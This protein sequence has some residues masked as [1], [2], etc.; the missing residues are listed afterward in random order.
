MMFLRRSVKQTNLFYF[1]D[2][3]DVS[4]VRECDI[5]AILPTPTTHKGTKRTMSLLRFEVDFF[6]V[7]VR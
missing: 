3:E 4:S 7:E 1:P 6:N 2:V 5:R